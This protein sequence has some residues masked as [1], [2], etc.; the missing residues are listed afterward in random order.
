MRMEQLMYAITVQQ[1]WAHAII[2]LGK[3]VENRTRLGT[4]KPA[5]GER[6]AIHAGKRLSQRGV[7]TIPSL[8]YMPTDWWS[9][10]VPRMPLGAILG[11]ATLAGLHQEEGGCCRPWGEPSYIEHGGTKRVDIV[12]LALTDPIP[13]GE[14]IDCRGA[15]GLWTVPDHIAAEIGDPTEGAP[16]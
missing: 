8:V 2:H 9:R 11:T 12:H 15:L 14:P 10:I 16:A 7:E 13:L 6:V 4:W 3:N 5:V 1:P